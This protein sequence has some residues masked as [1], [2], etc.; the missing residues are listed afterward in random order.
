MNQR[1]ATCSTILAVLEERGVKYEQNGQTPISEVLTDK[2]RADVCSALFAMFRGNQVEMSDEAK[3]KYKDDKA[4]KNYI[5]GLV[6]N[7][8]RKAPEFNAGGKYTPKN[9]GSRAGQGD[10][11]VKEMKK[12]LSQT[13]DPETKAVIEKAI[14]DRVA[15]IKPETSVEIDASKLP[16]SLRHLIK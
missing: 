9:P 8:V 1:K 16:E 6:S 14:A 12:L 3:E 15:E 11:Q 10:E 4:L 7:W 13:S 2:D 5:T